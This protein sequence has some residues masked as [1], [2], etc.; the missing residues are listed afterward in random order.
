[1]AIQKMGTVS[2]PDFASSRTVSSAEST[3]LKRIGG[4]AKKADLLA[5]DDGSG[6]L[7]ESRNI[8]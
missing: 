3:L 7:L 1:V 5:G 2:T 4:T 8:L 6:A